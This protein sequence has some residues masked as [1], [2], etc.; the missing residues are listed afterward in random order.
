MG[1]EESMG[2]QWTAVRVETTLWPKAQRCGHAGVTWGLGEK[3]AWLE[4]RLCDASLESSAVPRAQHPYLD[5][6]S[7][8]FEMHFHT[9]CWM[10]GTWR[11]VGDAH[12]MLHTGSALTELLAPGG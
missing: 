1:L 6:L 2:E 10:P 12:A 11:G 4:H 8:L 9:T 3:S 7:I 5:V